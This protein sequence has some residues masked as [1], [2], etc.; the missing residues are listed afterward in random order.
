MSVYR[1]ARRST[2]VWDTS[3]NKRETSFAGSTFKVHRK[4]TKAGISQAGCG[5]EREQENE[6]R[7]VPE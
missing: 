2:I 7:V 6:E 1:E 5:A 4:K 3:L